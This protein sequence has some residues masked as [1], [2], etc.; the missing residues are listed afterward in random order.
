MG[1]RDR[2]GRGKGAVAVGGEIGELVPDHHSV[3]AR[4]RRCIDTCHTVVRG[5][6]ENVKG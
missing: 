4:D 6:E 5:L 3:D 2:K 1:L